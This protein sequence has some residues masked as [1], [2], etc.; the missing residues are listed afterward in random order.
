M[1][2][3]KDEEA[4][5]KGWEWKGKVKEADEETKEKGTEKMRRT[6]TDN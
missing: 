2:T 5:G 1:E 6:Q 4:A 3:E